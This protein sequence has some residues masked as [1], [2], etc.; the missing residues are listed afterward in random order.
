M[1]II[2]T[3]LYYRTELVQHLKEV[4][5]PRSR[6]VIIRYEK[7][8]I[9]PAPIIVVGKDKL[10]TGAQVKEIAEFVKQNKKWRTNNGNRR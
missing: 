1:Q 6:P 10:Y 3:N 4:G 2:D 5:T 8:G 9:I 7:L